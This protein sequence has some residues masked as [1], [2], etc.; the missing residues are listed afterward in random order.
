MAKFRF[1]GDLPAFINDR[2]VE[3]G[4][5][6]DIPEGTVVQT[7]DV[8]DQPLFEAVQ[9]AKKATAAKDKE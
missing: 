7:A 4:D 1:L 9:A 2:L 5:V 3:P 6:V 8:T